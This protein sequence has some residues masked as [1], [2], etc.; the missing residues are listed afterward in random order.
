MWMAGEFALKQ[1]SS[2]LDSRRLPVNFALARHERELQGILNGLV[3]R[4]GRVALGPRL[5]RHGFSTSLSRHEPAAPARCLEGA[6]IST[7]P[8]VALN[9]PSQRAHLASAGQI[10]RDCFIGSC[11]TR[12][13]RGLSREERSTRSEVW[14]PWPVGVVRKAC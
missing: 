8:Q 2:R 9:A 4:G 13:R 14:P 11:T 3:A 1:A 6:R 12:L 7:E 10:D 5:I